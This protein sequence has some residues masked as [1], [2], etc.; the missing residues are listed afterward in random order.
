MVAGMRAFLSLIMLLG[1][2]IV[3][4]VVFLAAG[5]FAIWLATVVPGIVALKI[6]LPL[7][8]ALVGGAGVAIW[9]ALRVKHEPM[10]GVIVSPQ[11]A[12]RLWDEV[13]TLA[14]AA[15]TR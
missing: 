11:Q 6:T 5:G 10:P 7:F 14:Q 3:A 1:F 8:A 13:R 12:P 2:F 4:V 9:R 15:G